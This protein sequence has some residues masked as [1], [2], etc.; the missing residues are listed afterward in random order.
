MDL[1]FDLRTRDPGPSAEAF[2]DVV[3]FRGIQ[4]TTVNIVTAGSG[5]A[6]GY[7]F[8]PGERTWS[9][10]R[11]IQMDGLGTGICSRTRLLAEASDD[12]QFL[13][14]LSAPG[15]TRARVYRPIGKL[16]T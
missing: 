2:T 5:A 13:Q 12:L 3:P 6:C 14:T 11:A 9:M 16:G 1:R 4:A 7:A 8:K 10:R 15:N